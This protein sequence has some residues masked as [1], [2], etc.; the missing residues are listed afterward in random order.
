MVEAGGE[1]PDDAG[2]PRVDR[3]ALAR[4]GRD[5]V[6]LVED[7]E[8]L[9]AALFEPV[10]QGGGVT[11]VSEERVGDDEARVRGPGV[12]RPAALASAFRDEVAVV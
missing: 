10:A 1:L 2:E 4:R 8:R 12:E 5:V 7:E 3:V 11:L 9:P 6:G